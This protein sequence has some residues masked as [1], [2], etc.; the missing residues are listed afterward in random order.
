MR[1]NRIVIPA[2]LHLEMLNRLH[3]GHQGIRKCRERARQSVW[4]PGLSKQLEELVHNCPKCCKLRFQHAEPLV[5]TTFPSL[6]WQKVGTDL[7]VWKGANYLLIVDY[8]SRFIEI[9]KLSRDATSSEVI[10][11]TKS[12]F[13][14]H[15]IPQEVI[16][17]NG[18][19][20][21]AFEYARFSETYGFQ[22]NPSSPKYPQGNGEAERA[23]KTIKGYLNKTED[24]YLALL[25]Y[26]STPLHNGYSPSE[27]L[28][29]RRLRTT[30]PTIA[31]LLKPRL[32]DESSL[33]EKEEE[34]RG[35]QKV[36][37]DKHHRARGLELLTPG[38]QVWIPDHKT[39]GTV[40]KLVAPRS[41]QVSTPTGLLRRNRRHLILSPG[42][43]PTETV[44]NG[45][46][47]ATLEET[48]QQLPPAPDGVT[49]TRS[50]RASIPPKRLDPSLL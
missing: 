4:W 34:S 49:R 31:D 16:S 43:P 7:F 10:R 30:V 28:M 13:A 42:E 9:A 12:I 37:F 25:T 3:T 21:S 23:V 45:D 38:D 8:F 36:N 26:R 2:Q 39:N 18:P 35:K 44:Q 40:V 33:R 5:P 24:P 22:H 6:P 47:P 17:D 20:F 11:H 50:G 46:I 15:G 41:Y 32:P 14:R 27:L 19:Q 1:G 48:T 29:S